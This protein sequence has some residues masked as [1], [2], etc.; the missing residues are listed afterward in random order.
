[1]VIIEVVEVV[2][3]SVA[4]ISTGTS[5]AQLLAATGRRATGGAGVAVSAAVLRCQLVL[6]PCWWL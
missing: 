5:G 3:V 2:G 1:M 4:V 6:A